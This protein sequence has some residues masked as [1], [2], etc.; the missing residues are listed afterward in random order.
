MTAQASITKDSSQEK[1]R[2]ALLTK[3]MASVRDAISLAEKDKTRPTFHF[4]TPANWLND[5]NGPIFHR[6]WFHLF[7]QFNPY[8]DGWGHMHWGHARSR[9]MVHWEH[10]PI[11]LWPSRSLG[12]EHVFSGSTFP[13]ATGKP[14]ILYTSIG[15][16]REPE[17]WAAIPRKDDLV[18]WDKYPANPILNLGAHGNIAIREWRDPFCFR[19]ADTTYMVVGGGAGG[20]GVVLLYRA[21][22]GELLRWKYI[23]ILFTHPDNNIANIECPNIARLGERWILLTSTYGKVESFVG[24]LDLTRCAFVSEKRAVL[25]EASYAS[26]LVTDAKGRCIEWAWCNP[27]HAPGW[28]GCMTLPSVLRIATDGTLVRQPLPELATLREKRLQRKM[29]PLTGTLDLSDQINGDALEIVL[30]ILPGNAT[31]VGVRL[32]VSQEGGRSAEIRYEAQTRM[33]HIPERQPVP[34]PIMPGEDILKLHIFVDK[35]M[36][37]VYAADGMVSS[38]STL[39]GVQLE[40]VGLHLFA[41]KGTATIRS[42]NVY[43]MKPATFRLDM[44]R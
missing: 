18:I 27:P 30:E 19:E 11:A 44:F 17:Q 9:N 22:G 1:E 42:L 25:G 13:D 23:G 6:G 32:R 20:R 5:P 40:D 28:A 39:R 33:L 15:K 36:L 38:V 35:M 21:E 43:R 3:A 16:D 37:D 31:T 7:Y 26:Q 29:Q 24:R 41:E 4:H 2:I 8:G 14:V 34:I 10:L 12:E